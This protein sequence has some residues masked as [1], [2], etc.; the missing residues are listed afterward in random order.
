MVWRPLWGHIWKNLGGQGP[1]L[2][3][4]SKLR[5]FPP[6]ISYFAPLFT[7][8][9]V[10]NP[11]S[12]S[13]L[14]LLLPDLKVNLWFLQPLW[15]SGWH[16]GCQDA[17]LSEGRIHRYISFISLHFNHFPPPLYGKPFFPNFSKA[18]TKLAPL[19]ITG[20]HY[21]KYYANTSVSDPHQNDADPDP[22]PDPW[23]RI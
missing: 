9:R 16:P 21:Y 15:P 1:R 6:E 10:V 13:F 11:L 4:P 18:I 2:P 8:E 17:G 14:G 23:I 12:F 19:N 7:F 22:D 20:F 3:L 5:A